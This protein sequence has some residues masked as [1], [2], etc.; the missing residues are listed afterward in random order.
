[1]LGKE[2]GFEDNVLDSFTFLKRI[3]TKKKSMEMSAVIVDY[4]SSGMQIHSHGNPELLL[5]YCSDY[6]DGQDLQPLHADTRADILKNFV[7]WSE[8]EGYR[9][10]ALAY[11]PIDADFNEYVY[12][13]RSEGSDVFIDDVEEEH[14]K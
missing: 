11:K 10:L 12:G 14:C 8:R 13:S 5:S 9:C 3:Y 1:M 7:Q 4:D 2:I 6:W